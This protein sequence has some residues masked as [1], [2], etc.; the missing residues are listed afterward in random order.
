MSKD[1][2]IRS[3][4]HE[5]IDGMSEEQIRALLELLDEDFFS[6]E[7]TAAIQQARQETQCRDWREVRDDV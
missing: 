6:A 1:A 5:L 7:E 3:R 4:G 2:S